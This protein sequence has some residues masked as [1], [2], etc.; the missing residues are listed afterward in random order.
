M[1]LV[2]WGLLAG[3]RRVARGWREAEGRRR[4]RARAEHRIDSRL[5]ATG[6]PPSN[7]PTP[8]RFF[9]QRF[10][11]F[12][13]PDG[14]SERARTIGRARAATHHPTPDHPPTQPPRAPG[15]CE[16]QMTHKDAKILNLWAPAPERSVGTA[17]SVAH[18]VYKNER[19]ISKDLS[20]VCL[21]SPI[22]AKPVER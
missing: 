8:A 6:P 2:V 21:L 16:L 7:A 12:Y 15:E 17:L 19:E 13:F 3:C 22:P 11:L 18:V 14:A 10:F 20:A 9:P 5:P 1:N 4:E